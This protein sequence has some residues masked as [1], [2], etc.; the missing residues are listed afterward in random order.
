MDDHIAHAQVH[1]EA[2]PD[3][4]WSVLTSAEPRPEVMFGA[5]TVTDWH[6]GSD[7]RWQ[8]EWDGKPFEDRG[9]VLEVDRPHRLRVTHYSPLSGQPDE[10]ASYHT[11]EYVLVADG[12]GTSVTLSQ[13][14]NPTPEAATHSAGMWESM[15]AGV[16]AVAEGTG[17]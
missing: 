13:D 17:L 14:N 12:A 15:L 7:I 4:V 5:R 3:E 1:I 9:E 2:T 10:P 11:L 6:V 16:K 8:G